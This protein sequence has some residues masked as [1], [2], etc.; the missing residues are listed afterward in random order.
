MARGGQGGGHWVSGSEALTGV[1]LS[2]RP[3][4]LCRGALQVSVLG[5]GRQ[6]GTGAWSSGDQLGAGGGVA[7]TANCY[8]LRL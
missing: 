3:Q 5:G 1:W 4:G 2:Q 7:G 8:R 6:W